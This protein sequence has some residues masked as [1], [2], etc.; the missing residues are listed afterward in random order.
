[1]VCWAPMSSCSLRGLRV[2]TAAAW[3]SALLTLGEPSAAGAP[4]A[5]NQGFVDSTARCTTPDKAVAFGSTD[6][7]RVAICLTPAGQYQYRGVRVSDGAKLIAPASRSADGGFIAEADGFVYTVT[8]KSLVVSTGRRTIRD[9]PMTYFHGSDLVT[10]TSTAT[11]TPTVPL[12]PPLPA[13]A[14]GTGR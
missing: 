7:S 5:D 4:A 9:E 13:E 10:A 1:M 3:C 11:P 12:P 8:A 2:A 14:G 6:S